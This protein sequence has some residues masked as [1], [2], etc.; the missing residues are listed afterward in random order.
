[1]NS[2]DTSPETSPN[3]LDDAFFSRGEDPHAPREEAPPSTQD[4]A[5]VLAR[6]SGAPVVSSAD[7]A[8][9]GV[10]DLVPDFDED[11]VLGRNRGL[12]VGAFVLVLVGA[13]AGGVAGYFALRQSAPKDAVAPSVSASAKVVAAPTSP[14]AV[15]LAVASTDPSAKT[16]KTGADSGRSSSKGAGSGDTP[17]FAGPN[18]G[19]GAGPG[20]EVVGTGELS[21]GEIS[22]VVDRNRPLL[23]RRCWQ[24]EVSA[25]QGMGGSA[26]V[27]ASF[28]IGP[29]GAVQSAS[30]SGAESDYPGLAGC[31][32][33]RIREWK[34]PASASSTPVN[35]PF[36]FAA[37]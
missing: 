18:S 1:M 10:P 24:P 30:A 20:R 27:N 7:D 35:V 2:D 14:A 15:P 28:T 9:G 6:P 26:R 8:I 16:A 19:G 25:R 4:E 13:I 36:V 22:G 23:K 37:Q 17:G 12:H 5:S 34:F 3:T 29:S 11:A 33:A 21:A 31:I 32:A